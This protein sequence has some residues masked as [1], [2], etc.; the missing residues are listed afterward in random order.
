MNAEMI[1][2]LR[3]IETER[4]I[5]FESLLEALESAL[6]SAYKRNFGAEA[7]AIVSIDRQAGTMPRAETLPIVGFSPTILPKAA[8]TRP[9]PAVSV[10]SANG[11]I[12]AD[13]AQ[14]EPDD[15]PP[16]ASFGSNVL[17][18]TPYGL[19]VPTRPVAN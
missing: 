17:R 15:E 3:E 7:N 19:R 10:P 1:A 16:G 8:G 2:A 9:D 5:S 11:T 6:I 4:N 18:G 14:A 13:T 12:P